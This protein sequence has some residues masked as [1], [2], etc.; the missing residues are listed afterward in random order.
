VRFSQIGSDPGAIA[1]DR[2]EK[3][4]DEILSPSFIGDV[5]CPA[6]ELFD[7]IVQR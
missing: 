5:A 3:L 6:L 4:D 1:N 7:S 2:V